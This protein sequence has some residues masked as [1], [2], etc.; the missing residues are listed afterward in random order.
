[1]NGC[2]PVPKLG[3]IPPGVDS[4]PVYCT[5]VA[6]NL[7]P[8]TSTPLPPPVPPIRL[9]STNDYQLCTPPSTEEA[10]D[11]AE[12][13]PAI[14]DPPPVPPPTSSPLPPK[15]IPDCPPNEIAPAPK[16][17]LGPLPAI[18]APTRPSM[19]LL[20]VLLG[21]ADMCTCDAPA[22]CSWGNTSG[23]GGVRSPTLPIP[24]GILV[25]ISPPA[26]A[27]TDAD[28]IDDMPCA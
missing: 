6:P 24:I 25:P 2:L 5:G 18:G 17:A 22:P 1:M 13:K 21:P 16:N 20:L 4:P 14:A 3:V 26:K 7:P 10:A 28:R 11:D 8:A 15:D 23:W 9:P 12:L 19:L 27:P